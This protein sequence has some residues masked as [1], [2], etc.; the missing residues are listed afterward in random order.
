[1][2]ELEVR[3][4]V[5]LRLSAGEALADPFADKLCGEIERAIERTNGA[6]LRATS[7]GGTFRHIGK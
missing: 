7:R 6:V 5:V 2:V 3:F 4:D 1:M